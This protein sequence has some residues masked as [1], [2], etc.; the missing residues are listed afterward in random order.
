MQYDYVFIRDLMVMGSIGIEV[1]EKSALQPIV[2]SVRCGIAQKDSINL[3]CNDNAYAYTKSI[4]GDDV[5]NLP[6][7]TSH[8]TDFVCYKHL[9]HDI[10]EHI[11]QGHIDLVEDLAESIAHI[12]LSRNSVLNVWVRV[13]KPNAIDNAANVGIEIT[14]KK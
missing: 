11:Q 6:A 9:T 14:R 5:T 8:L 12:A 13:G 4:C 3:Y 1:H 10:V 7:H 2:I